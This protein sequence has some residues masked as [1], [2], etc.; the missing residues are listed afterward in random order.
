MC[1]SDDFMVSLPLRRLNL[2][3]GPVLGF[4]LCSAVVLLS[5]SNP[6]A[7]TPKSAV[8]QYATALEN[9]NWDEAY[10]L[11]SESTRGEL[12]REEF[13]ALLRAHPDEVRALAKN[14]RSQSSPPV[15]EAQ[16]TT[17]EGDTLLLTYENGSWKLD[18]RAVDLYAQ[19]E[20]R[21]ALDSFVKAFDQRRYEV[22][23]RFVPQSQSE[24]LTA[25]VL[26]EAWE[27]EQRSEMELMVEQLRTHI[28]TGELEV[29]GERATMSYG[30]GGTV[31]LIREQG[32]WKI[33]DLK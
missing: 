21:V 25:A 3:R 24:G 23:L 14:L 19:T 4:A 13:E 16:V 18:A 22:L 11:L 31:E 12:S 1:A 9:E 32:V 5:C 7:T 27:G 17:K 30:A 29:L 15:V 26:K 28:Q 10:A 2:P 6:R 33:E 8:D 20:P